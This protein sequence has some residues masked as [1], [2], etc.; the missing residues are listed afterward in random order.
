MYY[1][2]M[3]TLTWYSIYRAT[4]TMKA[5]ILSFSRKSINIIGGGCSIFAVFVVS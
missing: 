2:D 3:H 5:K 4:S 1:Y